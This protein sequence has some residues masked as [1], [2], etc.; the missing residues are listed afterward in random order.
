MSAST[1]SRRSLVSLREGA[2]GI[3]SGMNDEQDRVL[4]Y[5]AMDSVGNTT[6]AEV[7][8]TVPHVVP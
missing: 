3:D 8:V 4:T 6:L 5:T 7:I 2:H 1:I